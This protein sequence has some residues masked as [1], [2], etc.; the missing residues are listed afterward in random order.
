LPQPLPVRQVARLLHWQR[1]PNGEYVTRVTTSLLLHDTMPPASPQTVRGVPVTALSLHVVSTLFQ[2]LS[3]VVV[4]RQ[5]SA[6]MPPTFN[7]HMRLTPLPMPWQS[8]WQIRR[9]ARPLQM[10]SAKQM[11]AVVFVNMAAVTCCCLLVCFLGDGASSNS[12]RASAER[13]EC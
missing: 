12:V 1:P 13:G 6:V 8:A 3:A 2:L 9:W 10:S 5:R 11:S 4:Q 7:G